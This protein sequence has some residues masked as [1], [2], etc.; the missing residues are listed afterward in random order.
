MAF[1]NGG[2]I[3]ELA[4]GKPLSPGRWLNPAADYVIHWGEPEDDDHSE[5]R[6]SQWKSLNGLGVTMY[7]FK[8]D[9]SSWIPWPRVYIP[10]GVAALGFQKECIGIWAAIPIHVSVEQASSSGL[11]GR[12]VEERVKVVDMFDLETISKY[13]QLWDLGSCQSSAERKCIDTYS[14]PD[15]LDDNRMQ[16][17]VY[18]LQLGWLQYRW[19]LDKHKATHIAENIQEEVCHTDTPILGWRDGPVECEKGHL[20]NTVHPWVMKQMK[21][22][23]RFSFG[24]MFRFCANN[25]G[26]TVRGDLPTLS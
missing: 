20:S 21:E 8:R 10:D 17:E 25:C 13:R 16:D 4:P 22:M 1:E 14:T 7:V 12:L 9:E 11:F 3:S 5:D 6:S 19:S 26:V 18:A 23:P 24:I 15:C 2:I